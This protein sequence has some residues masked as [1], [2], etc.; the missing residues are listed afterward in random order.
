MFCGSGGQ[1]ALE[2]LLPALVSCNVASQDLT[3]LHHLLLGDDARL[4]HLRCLGDCL[5]RFPCAGQDSNAWDVGAGRAIGKMRRDEST[6][7]EGTSQ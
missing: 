6:C 7:C 2:T 5:R 4:L 3:G 1:G